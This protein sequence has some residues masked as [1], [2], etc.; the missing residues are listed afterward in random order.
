MAVSRFVVAFATA[1]LCWTNLTLAHTVLS[2]PGWRG[3]NL[4]TN[5]TIYPGVLGI[6]QVNGTTAFPYGAAWMYPCGGLPTSQ[7]RTLWPIKGGAIAI[8]PGWFA[9]HP[10]AL[11]YINMGF[12]NE[13]LNM[14]NSMVPVFQISGPSR[15]P[16]PGTFCLP[17]VPLPANASVKAG[18]NATIQVI[19][20]ALH[21]AALYSCAD[22]TFAEPEDVPEVNSSNCFN[23]SNIGFNLVFTTSALSSAQSLTLSSSYLLAPVPFLVALAAQYLL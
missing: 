22:I 21:G 20:T 11:F 7:N 19:Q 2:Y 10:T 23:S 4:F 9:N 1:V 15:D 16:Y 13:P 12:G 14:S 6:D 3:N 18:D 17:Q 8:Q 5:G